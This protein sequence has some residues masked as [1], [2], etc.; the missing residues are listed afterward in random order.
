MVSLEMHES[1]VVAD[2]EIGVEV[3]ADKTKYMVIPRN[4]NT[5]RSHS[6][7]TDNKYFEMVEE[8]KYLGNPRRIKIQFSNK[9]RSA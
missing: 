4:R 9:L 2:K 7:K 5:G 1:L 6:I 8:F 3:N